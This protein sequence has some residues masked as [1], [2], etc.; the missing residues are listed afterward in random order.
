MPA[1]PCPVCLWTDGFHTQ[2]VHGLRI[3]P[4]WTPM[5]VQEFDA[6]VRTVYRDA[7]GAIH[8]VTRRRV[9]ATLQEA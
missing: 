6:T 2:E 3:P 8:P 1:S 4:D 9:T 5:S 7:G